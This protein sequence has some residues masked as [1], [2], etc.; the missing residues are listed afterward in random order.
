M[1]IFS[2]RH[3]TA[4]KK[5]ALF[6]TKFN[7]SSFF[8]SFSAETTQ[9]E[10][11]ADF[12]AAKRYRQAQKDRTI[13]NKISRTTSIIISLIIMIAGFILDGLAFSVLPGPIL[14]TTALL[15]G[16]GLM[17]GGFVYFI[18]SAKRND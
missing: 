12:L 6:F 9:L 13:M 2:G 8:I 17:L 5:A 11:R 1:S 3:I 16:L 4:A 15:L 7:F 14:N 10:I 18:L